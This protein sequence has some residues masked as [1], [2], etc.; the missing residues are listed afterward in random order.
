MT[1]SNERKRRGGHKRLNERGPTIFFLKEKKIVE[2]LIVT[3][4]KTFIV[5]ILVE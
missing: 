4:V 5:K 2:A 1:F 3:I